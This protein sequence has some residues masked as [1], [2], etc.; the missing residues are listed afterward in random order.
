MNTNGYFNNE[1]MYRFVEKKDSIDSALE[2]SPKNEYL[3]SKKEDVLKYYNKEEFDVDRYYQAYG[4]YIFNQYGDF[5][6]HAYKRALEYVQKSDYNL[7]CIYQIDL[8]TDEDREILKGVILPEYIDEY[9]DI[10]NRE[11]IFEAVRQLSY[12]NLNS[13]FNSLF[14]TDK[15]SLDYWKNILNDH[16]LFE[17]ELSG[18]YYKANADKIPPMGIMPIIIKEAAEQYWSGFNNEYDDSAE[19]LFNG[20]VKVLRKIK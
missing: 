18:S 4:S 5:G 8:L 3:K 7:D 20:H 6:M 10:L 19:Y 9:L 15:K 13:R 2:L 14:V 12:Q 1:K 11:N 17:L 16:D